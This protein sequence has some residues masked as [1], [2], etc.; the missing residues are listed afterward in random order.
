MTSEEKPL[1]VDEATLEHELG[2][3]RF[4]RGHRWV[5][6]GITALITSISCEFKPAPVVCQA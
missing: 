2:Y 1:L 4:S 3:D 6:V 5:I